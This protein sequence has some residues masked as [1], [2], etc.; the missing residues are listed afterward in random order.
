MGSKDGDTEP[1][2]P[3]SRMH[4]QC[5]AGSLSFISTGSYSVSPLKLTSSLSPGV[6]QVG[7]TTF[8]RVSDRYY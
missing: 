5:A 8:L 1:K 4:K 2:L 3:D 6:R 7:V